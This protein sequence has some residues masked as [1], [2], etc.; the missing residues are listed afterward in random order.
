[1]EAHFT[2]DEDYEED[3]NDMTVVSDDTY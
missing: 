3:L 1:M 2:D